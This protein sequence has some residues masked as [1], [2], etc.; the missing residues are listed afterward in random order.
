[1]TLERRNPLPKGRYWVDMFGDNRELFNEWLTANRG[2]VHRIS[3]ESFPADDGGPARDWSL[4]EVTGGPTGEFLPEWV[5]IGF[6]TIADS[7]VM[8]SSDTVTA[9]DVADLPKTDLEKIGQILLIG[10]ALTLGAIALSSLASITRSIKG[11]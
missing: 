3:V 6:P 10:G 5:G 11:R 2:L 9:P 7:S 8:S 4:F 1:M